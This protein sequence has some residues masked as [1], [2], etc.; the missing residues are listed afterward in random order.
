MIHV[1]A[2]CKSFNGNTAVSNVSFEVKQGET[3]VLLGTSG[4]GKTTTLKMINRLIEPSS[5][6]II[7]DD[8][9]IMEQDA[10]ELRRSIGY[11]IQD[12]GLFPHYT[13]SQN[14]GLVPEIKDWS[15]E[16]KEKRTS[17][18]ISMLGLGD[19]PDVE[20]KFPSQLSGGQQQRVGIARALAA[21][22][23]IILLDEPFGALDPITRSQVRNEFR[24]LETILHKTMILVTHD[25]FEAVILG[26]AICLMDKGEV[27]QIGSPKDLLFNPKDQF[28]KDFFNE[29]RLQLEMEVITTDQLEM[30]GLR[31]GISVN[32]LLKSEDD[33]EKAR[34]ITDAFY[35]VRNQ[36]GNGQ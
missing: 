14:I 9:D 11:V 20:N 18:L 1:E 15:V 35:Q 33:P 36:M 31:T 28:T 4:C 12:I 13:V 34:K 10:F 6:K 23:E 3:L 16:E 22:P 30:E 27:V 32:Q 24:N 8:V 7:I 2:L 26:D 19:I 5:G 17:E 25:V 29:N 21:N